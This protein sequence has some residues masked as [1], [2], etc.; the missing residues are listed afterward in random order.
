MFLYCINCKMRK[1]KKIIITVYN[2]VLLSK[3]NH[4]VQQKEY[5][6]CE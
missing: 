2:Q 1:L 5:K 4:K 6:E 3:L